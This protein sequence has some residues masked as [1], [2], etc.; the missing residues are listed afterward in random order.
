MYIY[1]FVYIY[2]RTDHRIFHRTTR[3]EDPVVPRTIGNF[4]SIPA[5][6][7]IK[8]EERRHY[9]TYNEVSLFS[10]ACLLI[11]IGGSSLSGRLDSSSFC[12]V[13]KHFKIK[14]CEAKMFQNFPVSERT[15]CIFI[16]T[17]DEQYPGSFV[18]PRPQKDHCTIFHIIH[19][20]HAQNHV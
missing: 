13:D 20:F 2:K 3:F 15:T 11:I 19:S 7:V 6:I 4:F 1:I 9:H 17:S 16:K 8:K 12:F 10:D 5:L 14:D 18:V